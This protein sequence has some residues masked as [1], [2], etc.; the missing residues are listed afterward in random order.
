MRPSEEDQNALRRRG[1]RG[2]SG[3][4]GIEKARYECGDDGQKSL[5]QIDGFQ[6]F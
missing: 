6:N 5:Q 3:R 1:G 2:T 4:N